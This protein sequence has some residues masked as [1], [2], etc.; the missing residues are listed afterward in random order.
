M[1]SFP[2]LLSDYDKDDNGKEFLGKK[3]EPVDFDSTLEWKLFCEGSEAAFVRI[4][5]H[6]FKTLYNLGRQF[7]GDTDLLKD[8]L[9]ETFINIRKKRAKLHKVVSVKAF[10]IKCYRNRI[11]TEQKKRKKSMNLSFSL[12]AYGFLLTP[13]HE[14]VLINRQFKQEQIEL[15]RE[16]LNKLTR[17]QREVVYYFYYNGLSYAQIKDVMGFSSVRAVRNLV[18]R[19]LSELKKHVGR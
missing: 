9:Q 7:S 16:S 5:N 14:S 6:Y 11:I 15:I 17:R 1:S 19:S 4:Y 13:S 12:G 2:G 3:S 8:T 18:Y 10:L